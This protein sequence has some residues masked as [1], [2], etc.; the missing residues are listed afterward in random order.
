[1]QSPPARDDVSAFAIVCQGVLGVVP[2]FESLP[3]GST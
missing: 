2:S 1:M 3:V